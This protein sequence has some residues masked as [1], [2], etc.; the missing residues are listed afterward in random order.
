MKQRVT[1]KKKRG[2]KTPHI[3]DPA[4]SLNEKQLTAALRGYNLGH[5]TFA[6]SAGGTMNPAAVAVT[7]QGEFFIR[8]RYSRT[9]RKEQLSFEHDVIHQLAQAG[10]PVHPPIRTWKGSRW[11]E[12]E[13]AIWEVFPVVRGVMHE[14]GNLAQISNAGKLLGKF[15][16]AT[17]EMEGLPGKMPR[18]HDPNLSLQG[19]EWAK[20]SLA[21]LPGPPDAAERIDR[22]MRLAREVG[23][24]V[25][26]SVYEVLPKCI[27]HGDYHPANMLYQGDEI[28]GLF[29][30]DWTARAPRAVDVVDGLLFFCARREQDFDPASIESLTQPFVLELEAMCAFGQGYTENVTLTSE[31]LMALP[32]LMRARWLYCRIDAMLRKIPEAK[33]LNFLLNGIE[34]PLENITQHVEFIQKGSWLN[35]AL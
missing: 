35:V 30:F 7:D 23:K 20:A 9:C 19:L 2:A 31:E 1:G 4:L 3:V 6:R 14:P 10:L 17:T 29:D 13:N 15:H 32:D 16:L 12:D 8:R 24:R 18:F 27:I 11:Y 33:K 34:T 26:G 21:R 25:P 28:A 5:L 22:L